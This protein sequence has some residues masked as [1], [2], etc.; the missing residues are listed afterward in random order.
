MKVFPRALACLMLF[1]S[2]NAMADG[3][4]ARGE[5]KSALCAACHM[6]DGTGNQL[7]GAPN[8][9]NN[10][11]LYGGTPGWIEQS[12]REGRNGQM[13]PHSDF[14]GADKVHLLATYVYSLSL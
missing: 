7:L 1:I 2:A 3:D 4:A 13:P 11:W 14:L 8:L 10:I 5:E 6:P 12:I 9:T